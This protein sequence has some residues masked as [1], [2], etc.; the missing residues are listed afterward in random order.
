MTLRILALI[1]LSLVISNGIAKDL[2]YLCYDCSDSE[3]ANLAKRKGSNGDQVFVLDVV[4][5]TVRGYEVQ[6]WTERDVEA[7]GRVQNIRIATPITPTSRQVNAGQTV[8]QKVKQSG[9]SA[10]RETVQYSGEFANSPMTAHTALAYNA[11][12]SN[13]IDYFGDPGSNQKVAI[14]SYAVETFEL[15]EVNILIDVEFP[16]GSKLTLKYNRSMSTFEFV[17]G[18]A[19]DA[20][21]NTI[22]E[23]LHSVSNNFYFSGGGSGGTYGQMYNYFGLMGWGWSGSSGSVGTTCKIS[24]GKMTCSPIPSSQE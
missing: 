11:A 19:K 5:E 2:A 18:S 12:M 13:V 22:P 16:D 8:I 17:P 24:D 14:I 6:V 9:G 15:P 10:W 21:N 3:A 20:D 7:N 1:V 4:L 23:T